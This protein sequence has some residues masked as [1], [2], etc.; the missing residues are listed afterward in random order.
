MVNLFH[1]IFLSKHQRRHLSVA[2]KTRHSLE[3]PKQNTSNLNMVDSRTPFLSVGSYCIKSLNTLNEKNPEHSNYLKTVDKYTFNTARCDLCMAELQK[4]NVSSKFF[5]FSFREPKKKKNVLVIFYVGN[6]QTSIKI[7]FKFLN[8]S[9]HWIPVG[10]CYS[11][12]AIYFHCNPMSESPCA[13]PNKGS[14]HR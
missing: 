3:I 11:S 5:S 1:F 8:T 14:R 2:I 4:K 6:P 9:Y 10:Y 7:N 12:Q 13:N